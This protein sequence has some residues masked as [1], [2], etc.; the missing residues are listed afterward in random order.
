MD[1]RRLRLLRE[2]ADR[3]TVTAVAKALAYT[4]SAVSQQLRALQAEVGVTLTEPAG[5]GLRLTDAGRALAARADE[6]LAVLDRAEAELNTYR[7]TPR[8]TVRVALFP[9]GALLLL[10]GLLRRMSAIR[11]VSLECRDVDMTPPEVQALVADFDIVV[12]H[13]DDQAQPFDSER[14][15]ITP[16]LREPLDV[17]LPRGHP[18][19]S[20][21]RVELTEL[22]GEPW[23]SVDIGFPV[24]D[25]LRS[26][27]VRTGTRP[28]VVQR[29]NDFRVIEALVADGFGVALLPRYTVDDPR[30]VLR[31]LA[32]VR[33]GR[34]VE[35]VSRRGASE[36]PAVRAV[37]DALLA[38]AASV[39]G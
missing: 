24:D 16:L 38:E 29:I 34:N 33:A 11:E 32:G 4:P 5:R 31:P 23:V 35:A 22:A 26:L 20:R 18:L 37:F 39:T 27:A 13:R 25:V 3:G 7:S 1:V 8:G 15:E 9:S 12:A 10:P 2:L 6:V 19:A 36:R 30:L 17:A 21:D 28:K 14:M